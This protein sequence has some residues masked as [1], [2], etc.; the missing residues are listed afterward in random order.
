M[1]GHF[2]LSHL[3]YLTLF[4]FLPTARLNLSTRGRHHKVRFI[5]ASGWSEAFWANRAGRLHENGDIFGAVGGLAA[6]LVS[7]CFRSRLGSAVVSHHS[8]T[9]SPITLWLLTWFDLDKVGWWQSGVGLRA[10]QSKDDNQ[11]LFVGGHLSIFV[12]WLWFGHFGKSL[13]SLDLDH[14]SLIWGLRS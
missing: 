1:G 10:L 4:G 2:W 9:V 5:P 12:N 6:P 11:N 7:F 3:F 8:A 13:L 14:P